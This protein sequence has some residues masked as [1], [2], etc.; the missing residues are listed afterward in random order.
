MRKE[1]KK[2]FLVVWPT[3]LIA[4]SLLF[5]YSFLLAQDS[6]PSN[7]QVFSSSA[8]LVG[9]ITDDGGDPNLLVWFE[10][11]LTPNLGSSTPAF[12]HQGKG[13]FCFQITGL[14]PKTTYY[15]RALAQNSAGTSYGQIQSFLTLPLMP[16]VNLK[17]NGVSNYLE[18]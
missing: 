9:E 5:Y 11:G 3:V 7:S 1:D 10:Y 18:V 6:C 17:G 4:F 12:S 8:I 15:Y 2:F 14:M 13:T 16:V